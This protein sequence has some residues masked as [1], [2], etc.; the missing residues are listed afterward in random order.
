[1]TSGGDRTLPTPKFL[2]KQLGPD[3]KKALVKI[4]KFGTDSSTADRDM[5]Q[6]NLFDIFAERFPKDRAEPFL[7]T[8]DGHV[9]SYGMLEAISARIAH[10]IA[11]H[12]VKAG[13][14]VA[15]QAEKTPEAVFLYLACLRAGAALLPLNP[16]YRSD[17]LEYF[18]DDAEPALVIG[19]P[20]NADLAAL[21]VAR[22]IPLATLD[23]QG[24][25]TLIDQ[26]AGRPNV[27]TTVPRAGQDLGAILYSSGTTGR[28]KGVMLS[29]DNLA[30]NALTLHKLW[31][32]RPDDVL[33]HALPIFHTHGLF[34]ALNTTLVN[35]SA[36]IFHNRF[37]PDHVVADLPRAT[38]F[39]GVPTYYMRLLA[40]P[41]FDRA[42]SKNIRLFLC[43]SAPLLGNAFNQFEKRTGMQIVERYGMTE[44]GMITSAHLDKPRRAGAVGWP[45]PDVDLRIVGE[46]ERPLTAGE[47][48]EIRIKGP[49]V[50]R[51]YWKKPEK[52]AED[53]TEGWFKTGDLAR[54]DQDGMIS[55]VGRT[56]DMIISGGF[57]VYPKE[58]EQVLDAIP[59]IAESAV[60][61]MPHPDFGEASLA[62]L[63]AAPGAAV[64]D[65]R[66]VSDLLKEKL[67]KYKV[68]K[69][70]VLADSL[71]RNAM[72]KVQKKLLR[73]SYKAAWEAA[74]MR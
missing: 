65:V 58:I 67:A 44:A 38:V 6:E 63:I 61:G 21:C 62:I 41:A 13:D 33:L 71:P 51:A 53:F 40:A 27:F 2:L 24:G 19:D 1:L 47:T 9:T 28:P 25:G 4:D 14:R 73:E 64:P 55:I 18:L 39:M 23:A 15:V 45:L 31:Q 60:V 66:A 68:P 56:N 34:V 52:T 37:M 35:G 69:L 22:G 70:I 48:G 3:A 5:A 72:G 20:A 10:C 30:S 74:T 49:N 46:D 43:G 32:F 11:D 12:G 17:E 50:F 54:I 8:R 26:S 29:H 16:A 59:S 42:A 57:N 36:I 7:T